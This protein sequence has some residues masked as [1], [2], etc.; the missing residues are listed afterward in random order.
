MRVIARRGFMN[1]FPLPFPITLENTMVTERLVKSGP[2][3]GI[4]REGG[5]SFH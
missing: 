1:I 4:G 2:G 5:E 3:G